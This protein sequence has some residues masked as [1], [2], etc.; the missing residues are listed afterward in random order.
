MGEAAY[1]HHG[2]RLDA[3]HNFSVYFYPTW[4]HVQDPSGWFPNVA[5]WAL[6]PQL[7]FCAWLGFREAGR[8]PALAP[9]LQAVALVATNRVITAQ[10]FVWWWSLLPLALPWL[11]WR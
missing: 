6:F 1:L 10:Y 8:G 4:L 11:P 9:L 5:K 7:A 3:Q 2:R